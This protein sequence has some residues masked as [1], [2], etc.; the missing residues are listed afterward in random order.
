M[1]D[2][3]EKK[4]SVEGLFS[5]PDSNLHGKIVTVDVIRQSSWS[6]VP[7]GGEMPELN[8]N[9]RRRRGVG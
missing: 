6:A 7:G 4:R 5:R 2:G 8:G 3:E 9:R 1:T